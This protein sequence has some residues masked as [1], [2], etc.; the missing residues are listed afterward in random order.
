[1]TITLVCRQFEDGGD[2]RE[3]YFSASLLTNTTS[4]ELCKTMKNYVVN[5]FKCGVGISSNRATA[6]TEKIL[7]L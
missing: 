4:S 6:L 3:N 2:L 1:M 7:K 5:E